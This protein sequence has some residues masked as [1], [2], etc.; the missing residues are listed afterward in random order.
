M[1]FM[2]WEFSMPS[3]ADAGIH[4]GCRS[5]RVFL[6]RPVTMPTR[7]TASSGTSILRNMR[8]SLAEMSENGR[9][10]KRCERVRNHT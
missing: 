2:I 1:V 6:L 5:S 10:A 7:P 3:F 9:G 8:D 4:L